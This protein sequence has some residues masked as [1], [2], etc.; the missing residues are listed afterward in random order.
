[1]DEPSLQPVMPQSALLA[2]V[3]LDP[4]AQID[5]DCKRRQDRSLWLDVQLYSFHLRPLGSFQAPLM[6]CWRCQG[7][8][9][10]ILPLVSTQVES[11]LDRK[12]VV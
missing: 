2:R 12:S 9:T 10:P 4:P 3:L 11:C 8:V 6:T 1:M 7:E 5:I